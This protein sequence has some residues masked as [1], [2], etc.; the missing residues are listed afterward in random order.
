MEDKHG[1]PDM[2][3]GDPEI[4]AH[5]RELHRR[6][7][8][9]EGFLAGNVVKGVGK[10]LE[11]TFLPAWR[12]LTQGETRWPVTVAVAAALAMQATLPNYLVLGPRWLL[13]SVGG[14]LAVALVAANPRRID[15]ASMPIRTTGLL[16]IGVITLA[17]GYSA[18]RLIDRLLTVG[19]T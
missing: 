5:H 12:R 15:R 13:P 14:A 7:S 17:N 16:L 19:Q 4:E 11:T 9:V 2:P 18:A 10:G 6:L 8:A 1:E 3:A